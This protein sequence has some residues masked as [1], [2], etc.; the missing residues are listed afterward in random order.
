MRW[1]C[2]KNLDFNPPPCWGTNVTD[3]KTLSFFITLESRTNEIYWS[4]GGTTGTG[5]LKGVS[6]QELYKS[7]K[8]FIMN[9]II[10]W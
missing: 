3:D 5:G 2:R 7:N 4:D 10:Q 1:H 8:E 6:C 9:M